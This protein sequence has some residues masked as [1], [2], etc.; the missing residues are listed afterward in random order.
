MNAQQRLGGRSHCSYGPLSRLKPLAR[1][2]IGVGAGYRAACRGAAAALGS[3]G[4][5]PTLA[6][7]GLGT[8]AMAQQRDRRPSLESCHSSQHCG[9]TGR[10]QRLSDSGK[11]DARQRQNRTL[12]PKSQSAN[13]ISSGVVSCCCCANR[14]VYTAEVH[15]STKAAPG[16][17]TRPS[18][19]LCLG[20]PPS[21]LAQQL[22]G[23]SHGRLP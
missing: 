17:S 1:L 9:T 12:A 20:P 2:A 6:L 15:C 16:A 4:L 13:I 3:A 5:E 22:Y 21:A 23:S 14:R 18:S 10:C 7:G 19:A 8:S 11:H